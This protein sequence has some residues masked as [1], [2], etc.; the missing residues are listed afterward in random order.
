MILRNRDCALVTGSL[1]LCRLKPDVRK[2]K[3]DDYGGNRLGCAQCFKYSRSESSN[4]SNEGKEI[5]V[6]GNEPD[7]KDC[8]S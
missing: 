4:T 2:N 6:H 8:T 3:L 5:L 7:F 1:I